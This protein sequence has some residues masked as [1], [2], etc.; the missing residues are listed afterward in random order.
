MDRKT[1]ITDYIKSEIMRNDKAR[2][3]DDQDLLS[4]G[5]LDSLG[6]LQLVA[7]IND[8]FGIEVPDRDVVYENFH[9]VKS[10]DDYL[11]QY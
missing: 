8:T 3:A 6:I 5:I 4:E 2:I 9:S 1:M 7:Y 10:L 11:Q